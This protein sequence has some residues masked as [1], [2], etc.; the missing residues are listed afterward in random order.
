L[1]IV[2]LTIGTFGDVQPCVALGIGLNK[3]QCQ[4]TLATHRCYQ[5][6]VESSGL[7]FYPLAGNP[8]E[9]STGN[10]LNRLAGSKRNFLRWMFTLH[11]LAAPAMEGIM[12]SCFEACT[13]TDAVVYS[14][15]A[16]IGYSIAEKLNAPSFI[17]CLQPMTPTRYFPSVWSP[18]QFALGTVHNKLSHA[19]TEQIYWTLNRGHI[20]HFRQKYLGLG[21]LPPLGPFRQQ[22][23][24]KQPFL[25]GFS[26]SIIPKPPD[27]PE[28]ANITGYW[29]LPDDS[30]WKPDSE[31]LKFLE[32]GRPPVYFGFGS[33]PVENPAK[34]CRIIL[35]ALSRTGCRAVF[36]GGWA[37]AC[38]LPDYVFRI[39]WVPHSWLFPECSL[40]VHHG[41]ASTLANGL[42]AGVPSLV[43]PFAWDQ[44]FWGNRV[45][46]L[47][48][49][50]KPVAFNHLSVKNL[51]LAIDSIMNSH[52]I[53]RHSGRLAA[54]INKEQG[55]LTAANIITK[56]V[57]SWS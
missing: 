44:F 34:L 3:A 8:E 45:S 46:R 4:V 1:K 13:K 36:Q 37:S 38:E 21:P 53:K 2:I 7:S 55:T 52:V 24:V 5:Q 18:W 15:L 19:L 22:R 28:A 9:W 29:F 42:R 25:Y 47:E 35:E 17:A 12:E 31:L 16:W 20:N 39:G 48:V 11:S 54:K 43:I 57:G 32:K 51:V 23:W 14:P 41:G 30:S 6:F 26:P 56:H 10:E 50:P 40:V 27:W 49:G 33:M